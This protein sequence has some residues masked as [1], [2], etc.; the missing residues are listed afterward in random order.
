MIILDISNSLCHIEETWLILVVVVIILD[1][2][3]IIL[4]ISNSLCHIEDSTIISASFK[5]CSNVSLIIPVGNQKS[6]FRTFWYKVVYT[7]FVQVNMV[8]IGSSRDHF[9]Y[10]EFSMPCRGLYHH[11]CIF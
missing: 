3:M 7:Y 4:N 8:N 2:V 1:I 6:L 11:F 9:G 5:S 10:T